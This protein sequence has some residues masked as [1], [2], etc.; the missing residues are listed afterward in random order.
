M[1]CV[2][3]P[4]T[5]SGVDQHASLLSNLPVVTLSEKDEL[6]STVDYLEA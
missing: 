1:N 5:T 2:V 4:V 3:K 6:N